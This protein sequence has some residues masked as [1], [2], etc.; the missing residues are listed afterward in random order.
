[1]SFLLSQELSV[2]EHSKH[3]TQIPDT[4]G[5]EIAPGIVPSA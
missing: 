3:R 2:H 5:S 4:K 1:M